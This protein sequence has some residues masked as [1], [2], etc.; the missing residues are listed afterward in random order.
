[1]LFVSLV[2]EAKRLEAD[3]ASAER[4]L[5]EAPYTVESL[6]AE[7]ELTKALLLKRAEKRRRLLLAEQEKKRKE[8]AMQTAVLTL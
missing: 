4:A 5:A 2:K 3:L 7:A 6:E 8:K 1:M